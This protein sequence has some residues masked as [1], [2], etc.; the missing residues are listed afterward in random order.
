LSPPPAITF[1]PLPLHTSSVENFFFT[2]A[3]NIF[4]LGCVVLDACLLA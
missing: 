4:H 1:S 3:I 2:A